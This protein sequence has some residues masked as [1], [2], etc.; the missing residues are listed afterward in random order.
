MNGIK[1]L[2]LSSMLLITVSC[3]SQIPGK[4]KQI[5]PPKSEVPLSMDGLFKM[6]LNGDGKLS[7]LEVK[8]PILNDFDKLDL[9]KDGF[10]TRKEMS[11]APKPKGPPPSKRNQAPPRR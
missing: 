7:K 10:L 9:D 5:R 1:K 4:T 8:G 11:V 3:S 2:A 6:D